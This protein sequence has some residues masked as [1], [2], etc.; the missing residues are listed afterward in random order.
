MWV[1][2]LIIFIGASILFNNPNNNSSKRTGRSSM[3]GGIPYRFRKQIRHN[4]RK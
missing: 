1:I 2:A 3:S 4:I